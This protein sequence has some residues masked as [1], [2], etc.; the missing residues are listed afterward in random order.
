MAIA[1]VA[2]AQPIEWRSFPQ[3]NAQPGV[4]EPSAIRQLPDG[5][6]FVA[7]DEVRAAFGSFTLSHQ[8]LAQQ[9]SP[10]IKSNGQALP[11]LNDLEGLAQAPNGTLYAITS[12]SRTKAG[13][14]RAARHRF[15][16]VQ[17]TAGAISGL[18]VYGDLLDDILAAYPALKQA[19]KSPYA[20][21]RHGFNIEGLGFDK[22]GKTLMIGLRGPVLGKDSLIL[23][24]ENPAEV[25]K[26]QP[27]RFSPNLIRLDL[28]KGGIRAL[29]YIPALDMY[30]LV[31][32]KANKKGASNTASNLWIW[33]GEPNEPPKQVDI[34][35]LDLRNAEGIT[36]IRHMDRAYVFLV[37]DD[38]DRTKARPA[39]YLM[40]PVERVAENLPKP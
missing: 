30:L 6:L 15:V 35:G 36:Q 29:S 8:G 19:E 14:R 16:Q 18:T 13:K 5:R 11:R 37:S 38:G 17:L 2:C 20:K 21:G 24:L 7:Q 32:Q 27:P 10:T 9:F 28:N 39:H 4:F 22:S 31:A 40:L 3:S 1:P 12:F 34:P 26:G 23:R 33:S 25:F